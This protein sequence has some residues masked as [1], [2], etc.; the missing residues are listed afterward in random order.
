MLTEDEAR[1]LAVA[2]LDNED[3]EP[4][5][6]KVEDA[7][8]AWR[9]FYNSRVYVETLAVSHALVGNLPLLISKATGVVADDQTYAADSPRWRSE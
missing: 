2:H 3:W 6:M 5:V 9:V 1:A 8:T 4:A 7:G